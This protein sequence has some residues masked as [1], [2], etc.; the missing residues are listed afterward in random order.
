MLKDTLNYDDLTESQKRKVK[1]FAL[2][3]GYRIEGIT[4]DEIK[5]FFHSILTR[6]EELRKKLNS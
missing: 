6:N 5:E 2:S 4:D 1:E 3:K